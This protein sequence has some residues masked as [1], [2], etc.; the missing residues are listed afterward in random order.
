MARIKPKTKAPIL[1]KKMDSSC[2]PLDSLR[3]PLEYSLEETGITQSMIIKYFKC[4]RKWFLGLNRVKP[5]AIKRTFDF[6]NIVH[7]VLEKA[8]TQQNLIDTPEK[9]KSFVTACIDSFVLEKA[10]QGIIIENQEIA[11]AGVTLINFLRY[12]DIVQKRKYLYVEKELK[13]SFNIGA[14]R[15]V[16][17]LG[18]LDGAISDDNNTQS[19]CEYKTKQKFVD[20][21]FERLTYDF[22]SQFYSYLDPKL[23]GVRYLIIRKSQMSSKFPDKLIEKI[24]TDIDLD[25]NKYFKEYYIN[26]SLKDRE[27]FEYELRGKLR[28]ISSTLMTRNT[29]NVFKEQ[30]ACSGFGDCPFIDICK[31]NVIDMRKYKFQKKFFSELEK[32]G[33]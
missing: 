12:T 30:T 29:M 9:S 18:K 28:A 2:V 21:F 32:V 8:A 4:R 7:E 3:F 14:S 33:D 25:P 31:T 6:G 19:L 22:Q 17:L 27:R 16:K 1:I 20:S 15:P 10:K 23:S 24:Q 11:K 26:Y 13:R 5:L